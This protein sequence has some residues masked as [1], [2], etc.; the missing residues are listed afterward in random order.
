MAPEARQRLKEAA[1]DAGIELTSCIGLSKEFDVASAD[2][3]VRRKGVAFL[4]QLAES[5]ADAGIRKLGGIIYG[6]WPG[7]L[8]A[9]QTDKRPARERS[10][11]SM[12]EA[13]KTAEENDVVFCVE[14]VNRFEQY[15]LN[16]AQEA[17]QYVA[18]VNSTHLGILLDAFHMNIEEDSFRDAIVST[19]HLLLHLHVGETNRRAPGRGKMAWDEI[20]GALQ[21]IGYQ[22]AIILEPFLMPGGQIGRDISVFR[23][24]KGTLDLD[25]EA[26][27]ACGFIKEK[28]A[29]TAKVPRQGASL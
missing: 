2:E 3:A 9:G 1:A 21:E 10:V 16:T 24:L 18:E 13:I 6:C 29:N 12:R 17:I 19:G 14:V 26:R 20:F 15:L 4:K 23:D 22:D 11:A 27:R 25:E 8:P 28:L 7:A 5:L